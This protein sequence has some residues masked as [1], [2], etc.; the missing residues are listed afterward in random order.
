[1]NKKERIQLETILTH[2]ELIFKPADKG[3]ALVVLNK[4]YYINEILLQLSDTNVYLKLSADPLKSIQ[5]KVRN[6]VD[7]AR[8]DDLIDD[9]LQQFLQQKHP[10]TP[11]FYTL[12]KIHKDSK[13]PPGR[14]IVA[15]SDSIFAPLSIYLDKILQPFV[16]KTR[17]YL[18]DTAQLLGILDTLIVT[19]E[20]ILVT[21]DIQSLYTSIMHDDGIQAISIVLQDDSEYSYEAKE[22]FLALLNIVLRDN[23]FLFQDNFF[24]QQ[25]GTAMGSNVAPTYANLYMDF[26]ERTYVYT[27]SDFVEHCQLYRRYIDDIIMLWTGTIES[28]VAF[29]DHLNSVVPTIKFTIIHDL[30]RINFLDVWIMKKN[31]GLQT[32]LYKKE[33]DRNS[34]LHYTSFHP[35]A[36]KNNLPKTQFMRVKRVVS[37]QENEYKRTEEM[38]KRFSQRGYPKTLL[39]SCIQDIREIS[40]NEQRKQK[41]TDRLAFVSKFSVASNGLRKIIQKHWHILQTCAPHIPAFVK[42]PMMA[43]QR[44]KNFRD[45][46]IKA[47]IGPTNKGTQR[48]LGTPKMGTFPCLSCANCNNITKGKFFTHPHTG[49]KFNIANYYTCNST[50]VIYLIKCPCGLAYVGETTQ[51]IKDRIKQ[52]KSNIRC[53]YNHLPIPSHFSEA[54]HTVSQ[55]RYQVIDDVGPLRRGGD[56]IYLLKKLEMQWISRLGTLCPGGLNR[57]YTPEL[58]I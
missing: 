47:D 54:R 35:P 46:L 20:T 32:D 56:R 2:N 14:P 22:F 55:L 37:E 51:K 3:G 52:H 23:Y 42:A 24:L 41:D 38:R 31:S 57:E 8:E 7:K 28:L 29:C 19:D 33:T 6:T 16:I 34:L 13:Q 39:N 26:F 17:S 44:G 21:M 43:Y 12:P 50:F 53:N 30:L 5:I 4:S 49:R 40:Q 11:V 45:I 58:F 1:M 15:S 27:N 25:Q 18:K 48:F 10:I 36:L 9:K